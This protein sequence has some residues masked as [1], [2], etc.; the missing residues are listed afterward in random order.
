MVEGERSLES[1]F[2]R[3]KPTKLLLAL[4]STGKKPKY[5]SILS[6]EI[7]C[8]YSHTVRLLDEFQKIGLVKFMKVSRVKYIELTEDGRDLLLDIEGTVRKL[9]RLKIKDVEKKKALKG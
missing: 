4:G 6:K 3:E 9:T 7:N 2:L 1:L 8:T 5:V